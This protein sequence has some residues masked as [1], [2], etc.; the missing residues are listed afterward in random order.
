MLKK[1]LNTAVEICVV[2]GIN[3]LAD[4]GFTGGGRTTLAQW[5]RLRQAPAVKAGEC[6]PLGFMAVGVAAGKIGRDSL[7]GAAKAAGK[8]GALG[9][10]V[11]AGLAL[12]KAVPMYRQELIQQGDVV[13]YV[14]YEAGCGLAASAAGAAGSV[15]TGA[16]VGAGAAPMLVGLGAAIGA[17]QLYRNIVDNP[18]HKKVSPNEIKGKNRGDDA[19]GGGDDDDTEDEVNDILED[20]NSVWRE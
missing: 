11:D 17:R 8:A 1:L 10:A 4:K 19:D 9:A 13:H 20:L 15:L 5:E 12:H 7:V 14:A 6:L 2:D 16:V 18:L 3:T